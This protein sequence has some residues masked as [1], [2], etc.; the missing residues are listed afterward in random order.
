VHRPKFGYVSLVTLI[1][2]NFYPPDLCA[3]Y[4]M[5]DYI[6]DTNTDPPGKFS[7]TQLADY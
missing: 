6:K 2:E 3:N 1:L 7:L 4:N 5:L